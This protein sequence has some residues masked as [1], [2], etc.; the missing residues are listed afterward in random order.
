M[1]LQSTGGDIECTGTSLTEAQQHIVG[2]SPLINRES[3]MH[4][5]LYGCPDKAASNKDYWSCTPQNRS[6]IC[7]GPT[8]LMYE[9]TRDRCDDYLAKGE[10]ITVGGA[11]IHNVVLMVQYVDGGFSDSSGLQLK[12]M[13][14]DT[15]ETGIIETVNYYSGAL[16]SPSCDPKPLIDMAEDEDEDEDRDEDE[17]VNEQQEEGPDEG[18]EEVNGMQEEEEEEEE[19][20]I[21][22]SSSSLAVEEDIGDEY[23]QSSLWS[24]LE[25]NTDW[26]SSRVPRIDYGADESISMSEFLNQDEYYSD[27]GI[28][29]SYQNRIGGDSYM[30]NYGDEGSVY[31]SSADWMA[32]LQDLWNSAGAQ[33]YGMVLRGW[34]PRDEALEIGQVAGIATDSSGKLSLVHRAGRQWKDGVFD[35]ENNFL[36]DEPIPDDVIVTLDPGTGEVLTSWGSDRFYM[37]HG[38]YIDAHDNMWLT[39]VALH[40]VFKFPA[41][42]RTPTLVLGKAFDPGNDLDQFCKPTDVAVDSR[43]GEIYVAD[44]YCNNRVLKFTHNGTF[45]MEITAGKIPGELVPPWSPMRSFQIPHSLAI[46]ESRDI[47]CVA[48][49]E[50]ARIQCF[51]LTTGS[52]ERQ[53]ASPAF[54]NEIYAI[55]YNDDEDVL[56]AVNG[57]DE[58]EELP[59]LGFTVE[60]ERGEIL[61]TW[62]PYPKIFGVVHDIATYPPEGAV[63]VADIGVNR[64]WKFETTSSS[65]GNEI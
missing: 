58:G 22:P 27:Q 53:I 30:N 52:L 41:G 31:A 32:R 29:Q 14:S 55:A 38:L 49:R 21:L 56:Y 61:S 35:D 36:L 57:P 62:D 28:D 47:I 59:P 63:Y 46:I 39:D 37:P 5:A 24:I 54:G 50:N 51:N 10:A 34:W 9:W 25:Q 33:A 12:L 44:G 45:L 3:V 40:Q 4:I 13:P 2:F 15:E 17:A 26:M 20:E 43:T 8:A 42:S 6:G 1:H 48:D 11:F 19:V 60:L 23:S 16:K 65:L 18:D 7:H 64:V